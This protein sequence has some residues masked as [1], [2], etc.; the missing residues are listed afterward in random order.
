MQLN[1][2][3]MAAGLPLEAENFQDLLKLQLPILG[4]ELMKLI[5]K[6]YLKNLVGL[7]MFSFIQAEKQNSRVEAQALVCPLRKD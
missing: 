1:I 2:R 7:G 6:K 5:M 4:L 3:L